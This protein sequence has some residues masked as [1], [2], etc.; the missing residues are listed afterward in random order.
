M[1]TRSIN[2][3]V[4]SGGRLF[5]ANERD[6]RGSCGHHLAIL[7]RS[8]DLFVKCFFLWILTILLYPITL[9]LATYS[10]KMAGLDK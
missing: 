9:M 4:S 7:S 1:E 2:G 10:C 5:E 6:V 8:G 3:G